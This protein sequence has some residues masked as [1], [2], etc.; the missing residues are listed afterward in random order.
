MK[1]SM[2]LLSAAKATL[3]GREGSLD[4]RDL[5]VLHEVLKGKPL[6]APDVTHSNRTVNRSHKAGIPTENAPNDFRH[7]AK[8]KKSAIG[9]ETTMHLLAEGCEKKREVQNTQTR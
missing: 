8:S 2:E 7:S 9:R 4:A 3:D 5:H 1:P 6:A